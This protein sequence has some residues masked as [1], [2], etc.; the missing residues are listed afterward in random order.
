MTQEISG[1]KEKGKVSKP[2]LFFVRLIICI[3]IIASGIKVMKVFES[4][5]KPPAEI[6]VQEK[7]LKVE[8]VNV[9]PGDSEITITAYGEVSVLN[10]LTI[11]P[12]ISGSAIYVNPNLKP[13][14]MVDKNTLLLKIDDRNYVAAVREA[15]SSVAKLKNTILKMKKGHITDKKRVK[16]IKRNRDISQ[17]EFER[18]S[19]LYSV[20]KVGT[21]SEIEKSE[22]TMNT[23]QDQLDLLLQKIDLFPL[24]I[25]ETENNLDLAVTKLSLAETNLK[26]CKLISPIKG[27]V[28]KVMVEKG[29]YLSPGMTAV[30][31]AD[32]SILEI[33]VPLD[34]LDVKN[35][36]HFDDDDPDKSG[37]WFSRLKRVT[38]RIFW[39]ESPDNNVFTGVLH[40]VVDFNPQTRT[41]MIAIRVDNQNRAA[42]SVLNP[43]FPLVEGMF[44]KV[45]IPGK[46][47]LDV[48][49]L[50]RWA[51]TFD[52]TVYCVKDRR[53]R[54]LP[55]QILRSEGEFIF[56]RG[57][58]ENTDVIVT[59]LVD[60]LENTLVEVV[61]K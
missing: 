46:R 28:K 2:V 18:I 8:T 35:W 60:P 51:V 26:R 34:S 57:I 15:E 54:T 49:R 45:E 14:E 30:I 56:V 20:N 5:K 40:R 32:D 36:I 16:N 47:I 23:S 42:N 25:K 53:L 44:C 3:I 13:G 58:P 41:V 17:I 1:K 11:S 19:K 21:L 55:V 59:R 50:P 9:I 22:R 10:T 37:L 39:T 52:E 61:Q 7:I 33:H 27:R 24:E 29:Q 38:C 43:I 48:V 31:L 6:K 12:E 4:G